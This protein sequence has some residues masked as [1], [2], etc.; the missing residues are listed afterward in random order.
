MKKANAKSTVQSRPTPQEIQKTLNGTNWETYLEN[1]DKRV[2]QEVDA[3][4]VARVRSLE[5]ASHQVFL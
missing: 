2:A 1:V 3:F 5:A 4:E